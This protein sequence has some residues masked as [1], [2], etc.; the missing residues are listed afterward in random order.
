M[1]QNHRFLQI[2]PFKDG[3]GRVA[4]ELLNFIL[5]RNEYPPLIVPISQGIEYFESLAKADQ[6]D[7]VPLI[8]FFAICIFEDYAQA[9]TN[10]FDEITLALGELTEEESKE[11]IKLIWWYLILIIDYLKIIPDKIDDKMEKILSSGENIDLISILGYM[12]LK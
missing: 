4:R 2:H 7:P 8:E 10:I 6:G 3:N 1:S 11:V 12:G 5:I 9:I